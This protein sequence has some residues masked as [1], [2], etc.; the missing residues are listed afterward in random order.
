MRSSFCLS[1]TTKPRSTRPHRSY[2]LVGDR[3]EV[4]PSRACSPAAAEPPQRPAARREQFDLS[5]ADLPS[6]E[7]ITAARRVPSTRG[8]L[9]SLRLRLSASAWQ[10]VEEW[11]APS[12]PPPD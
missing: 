5:R 10:G 8:C 2:I 3:T 12:K 1:V 11:R 6:A 7:W 4:T 9:I